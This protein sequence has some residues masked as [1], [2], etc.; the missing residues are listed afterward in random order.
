MGW[1]DIFAHKCCYQID[2]LSSL[3]L[4]KL[5]VLFWLVDIKLG[6]LY[7]HIDGYRLQSLPEDLDTLDQVQGSFDMSHEF[8]S[9]CFRD[10]VPYL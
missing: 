2:G 8:Y 7:S 1:L 6:V 3:R 5:D 9:V 10:V 4:I